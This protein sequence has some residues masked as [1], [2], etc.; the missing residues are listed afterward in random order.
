VNEND[1]TDEAWIQSSV[2]DQAIR[3]RNLGPLLARGVTFAEARLLEGEDGLWSIF[4]RLSD[5]PGE[6]RLNQYKSATPKTYKD[7]GFAIVTLREDFGYYGP[8][9]LSTD[10]R[11]G[12]RMAVTPLDE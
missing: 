9:T 6:F 7:V 12:P 5:R 3:V 1:S 10:M 11:P 4:V 2:P 8:I